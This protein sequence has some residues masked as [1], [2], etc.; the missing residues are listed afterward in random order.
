MNE[1]TTAKNKDLDHYSPRDGLKA[2]AAWEV[3]EKYYKRARDREGLYNAIDNKLAEQCKFVQWWDTQ[4]NKDKGGGTGANQHRAAGIRTDTSSDKLKTFRL[5][6][7][8]VSRWRQNLCRGDGDVEKQAN[9]DKAVLE[10]KAKALLAVEYASSDAERMLASETVEWYTPPHIIEA[11]RNVLGGFDLDPASNKTANKWIKAKKYY[12]AEDSGLLHDWNGRIWLNPPY[13]GFTSKFINKL[14]DEVAAGNV[15][16]AI[17]LVNAT[18]CKDNWFQP[19]W[20][21]VLCF[22]Q[23][24]KFLNAGGEEQSKAPFASVA[25]YIGGNTKKFVEEFNSLGAVMVRVNPSA[26]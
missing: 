1:L 22:M 13:S 14:T 2:I 11:A 20:D 12:T 3:A 9:Y 10:A 7:L 21:Y 18:G 4:A 24:L 23:P 16:E 17:C 25:V 6:K 15:E 26:F 5:D 19:L 8:T